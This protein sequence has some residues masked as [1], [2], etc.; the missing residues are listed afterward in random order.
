M[1]VYDIYASS[2]G[3]TLIFK[4]KGQKRCCP[5]KKPC[6][7]PSK[8]DLEVK[9]Q[10]RIRIINERNISSHSDRPM[11]QKVYANVKTKRVTG[12]TRICTDRQKNRQRDRYTDRQSDSYLLVYGRFNEPLHVNVLNQGSVS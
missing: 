5:D 1:N 10:R 2:N 9:G 7:K 3:D 12:W 6:P 4:V 8:I 11:C